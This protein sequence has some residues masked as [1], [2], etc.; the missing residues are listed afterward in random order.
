MFLGGKDVAAGPTYQIT[1]LGHNGHV[2]R[3]E[4]VRGTGEVDL[5]YLIDVHAEAGAGPASMRWEPEAIA[6]VCIPPDYYK[7]GVFGLRIKGKSMEPLI[8]RDAFVGVDAQDR[9][10][11]SGDIYAVFIPHEG[12]RVKQL[13]LDPS[14]GEYVLHSV[15]PTHPD[16]RLSIADG[17]HL[18]VGRVVWV[19]QKF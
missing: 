13:F 2:R 8:S 11:V 17:E 6:S 16:M 19:L 18:I 4:V 7:P 5:G 1:T 10:L 14:A 15:N 9:E 12:L 3:A